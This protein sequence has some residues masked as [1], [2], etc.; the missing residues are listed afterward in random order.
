MSI[1][2]KAKVIAMKYSESVRS[3][4][5]ICLH[6]F[7]P[8]SKQSFIVTLRGSLDPTLDYSIYSTALGS[9]LTCTYIGDT[10]GSAWMANTIELR[11]REMTK[12]TQ[13]WRA[14]VYALKTLISSNSID[15]IGGSIQ[16][17]ITTANRFEPTWVFNDTANQK[18]SFSFRNL[19]LL[20][21]IGIQLGNCSVAI[22]GMSFDE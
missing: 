21:E 5:E 15:T 2:E 14:P 16:L 19:D 13:Y 10:N 8:Q 6:G 18:D 7:C 22:N 17:T 9:N 4:I 11:L 12:I 20:T 1:A 3:L